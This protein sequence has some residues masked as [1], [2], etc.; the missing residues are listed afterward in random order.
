MIKTKEVGVYY[1]ILKNK[2]KIFYI[3]YKDMDGKKIWLK[4]GSFES[5][6]RVKHCKNDREAILNQIRRGQHQNIITNK[7]IKDL[8]LK[9]SEASVAY[10]NAKVIEMTS[11]NLKASL[12]K[13]N[14]Y[15]MP[16]FG[17]TSIKDIK[18]TSI[19]TM[20]IG[21]KKKLS[22]G[23]INGIRTKLS[24]IINF[25]IESDELNYNG[26]NVVESVKKFKVEQIRRRYLQLEEVKSLLENVKDNT[27]IYIF[28]RLALS[29]GA[30]LATL[31]NLKQ[32]EIDLK[33]R[34]LTLYD[35]KNKSTYFSSIKLDLVNDLKNF[36]KGKKLNEL[37]FQRENGSSTTRYVQTYLKPIMDVLYNQGLPSRNNTRVVVH[38][39]RHTFASHLVING[40]SIYKVMKLLNHKSIEMTM[41]YAHLNKS[42]EQEDIDNLGF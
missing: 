20:M 29:T 31:L 35:F 15:L 13:Y 6:I 3:T 11:K 40:T 34:T 10:H 24:A 41:R 28:V 18:R 21:L 32:S 39:L 19:E 14:M 5:G 7:R 17:N 1:K 16:I 9:L 36:I 27:F 42:S 4:V 2:E 8:E 26:K 12:S 37:I 30:R 25:A 33:S 22:D 23:T 38:T